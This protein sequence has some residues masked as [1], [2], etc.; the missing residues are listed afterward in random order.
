M[1]FQCQHFCISISKKKINQLPSKIHR[2]KIQPKMQKLCAVRPFRAMNA[3][4]DLYFTMLWIITQSCNTIAAKPK[5]SKPVEKKVITIHF[6]DNLKAQVHWIPFKCVSLSED[7]FSKR[8]KRTTSEP[9]KLYSSQRI[10]VHNLGLEALL[11]KRLD[12]SDCADTAL[13]FHLFV[14]PSSFSTRPSASIKTVVLTYEAIWTI[15]KAAHG[16]E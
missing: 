4:L 10:G 12:E 16:S 9:S 5:D 11:L 8:L 6:R 14:S 15:L 7:R 3:L 13:N 1:R 2:L